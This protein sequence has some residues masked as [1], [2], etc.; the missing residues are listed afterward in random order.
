V[1]GYSSLKQCQH[2]CRI[3]GTLDKVEQAV[4]AIGGVVIVMEHPAGSRAAQNIRTGR[5]K[6]PVDFTDM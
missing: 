4:Q 2:I 6:L 3:L 5:E 1:Y